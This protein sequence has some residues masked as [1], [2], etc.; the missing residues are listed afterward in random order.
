MMEPFHLGK[1]RLTP[2][3]LRKLSLQPNPDIR[4]ADD[5]WKVVER[6]RGMVEGFL[7][8]GKTYYGI[9][10]GFG[11]LSN[12]RIDTANL[13]ALQ[14]NLVRSHACGVG[15]P[16]SPELVRSLMIIRAHTFCLGYSGVTPDTVKTLLAFLKHDILPIVP[17][18][19]SVGASGDLAPLAHI[20][21]G[22]IGEGKCTYQGQVKP[23]AQVLEQLG[24]KPV[25][26]QAKEGLSLIN[27]TH[28]MAIL[29][30][31]AVSEARNLCKS[32][33]IIA[34]L[35]LDAIRGS[36]SPFDKR[37]HDIRPHEGQ[38]Q[39][40]ANFRELFQEH[41]EILESHKDCD[42][43]QDPYSFRCIPQVHGASR[44]SLEY[45][46]AK[47]EIELGSVT[48]NPLCFEE[49][50]ISG[51]NFH[52]QNMA[53]CLDFLGMAMS[54]LGNIS[55]RRIEKMT[56]PTMS[57][58]P[59]FVIK[60]SGLNSGFMI[61]H[62]VAAA[63]ASENKTLCHPASVDSIP[64]SA[65]KE[66]HVSMGPIAGRKCR[67]IIDNVTNILAIELL[68][69]CQGIDLLAPSRPSKMLEKVYQAVRGVSTYI[70]KDRSIAEDIEA[71]ARMISEGKIV[72]LVEDGGVKLN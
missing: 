61:P 2:E 62:V 9:N 67:Q 53:L 68:A 64:T 50:I 10:T 18:K 37:I 7:K 46:S 28:F 41:D 12:V 70:N 72:A 47:V 40:A 65:D 30:A 43:V 8:S 57:G 71:V 22:L 48:D 11:Y 36:L 66:D 51:G 59:A 45:V 6:Y 49:G 5:T 13:Q 27:G 3:K 52:G 23:V 60:D 69:A 63:L 33:D 58:L 55:E 15:N 39:V 44:D 14:Q 25:L 29:G 20:A 19:G 21:L 1:D 34:A 4:V 17:E 42:K 26:L 35:S 24:L 32:A 38:K 54:E 16:L 31:H 56:N